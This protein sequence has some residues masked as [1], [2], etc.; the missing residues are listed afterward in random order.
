[1]AEKL[2]EG[3]PVA[4]LAVFAHPDDTESACGGSLARWAAGG[5]VVTVC[6]CCRG[7]KGSSDP[8]TKPA[9]LVKTRRKEAAGAAAELQVAELVELGHPDG[10]LDPAALRK[11]IVSLI[12]RV[13]PELV[14]C[15][16]PT[17]VLFA[18]HYVNHRDHR[19]VGW[20]VLDAAAHEAGLPAYW[21]DQGPPHQPTELWLAGTL[22]PDVWV[23]ISATV[24]AK[25]AALACHTSQLD[26][27]GEWL[28]KV[29]EQRAAADGRAAGV[30]AAEGFRRLILA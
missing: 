5:A 17:A 21:P 14:V 12:R 28:T 18:Q 23:D 29:V 6:V 8:G 26:D 27:S 7:D 1:L 30:P 13:K 4:A 11:E 25:S 16:D 24:A 10:E 9:A 3:V 19:E 20:A 15:P 22:Q 2:H